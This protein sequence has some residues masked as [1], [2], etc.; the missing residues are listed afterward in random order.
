[1]PVLAATIWQATIRAWEKSVARDSSAR[2]AAHSDDPYPMEWR[3]ARTA[4]RGDRGAQQIWSQALSGLRALGL[5]CILVACAGMGSSERG[6]SEER[7]LL[8]QSV[9]R[10]GAL[11]PV[12][13]AYST[14]ALAHLRAVNARGGIHGRRIEVVSLDDGS[15][16]RRALENT[17]ELLYRHRVFALVNY[18]GAQT[19]E[20]HR[21][22]VQAERVPMLAPQPE[23]DQ[24]RLPYNRYLFALPPVDAGTTDSRQAQAQ[25]YADAQALTQALALA[26]RDLTREKL[27]AALEQIEAATRVASRGRDLPSH[28]LASGRTATLLLA[29]NQR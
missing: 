11:A 2:R 27:V 26:G 21:G 12:A 19:L 14:G 10:S 25:G 8:G 28:R 17:R 20:A 18:F 23:G 13:Q 1:M 15:D 7:I 6:V 4:Q 29:A 9:P 16:S 22:I 24:S 3:E 5:A